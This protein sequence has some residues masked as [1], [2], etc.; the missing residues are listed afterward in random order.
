MKYIN[1][2]RVPKTYFGVTL[3]PGE[4]VDVPGKITNKFIVPVKTDNS[5]AVSEK[6][7][8]DDSKKPAVKKTNK[9][10][11]EKESEEKDG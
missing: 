5:S 2:G 9:S 4:V 11:I 10:N 7:T 1:L 8:S 6:S 3:K